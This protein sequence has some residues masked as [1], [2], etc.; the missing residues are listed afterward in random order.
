MAYCLMFILLLQ[1]KKI[2]IFATLPETNISPE[3]RPSQKEINIPTIHFQVLLLLVSGRVP[4]VFL[5]LPWWVTTSI[6]RVFCP[7]TLGIQLGT[8]TTRALR[9]C[10][11]LQ[12]FWARFLMAVLVNGQPRF[13]LG[14][15]AGSLSKGITI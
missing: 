5:G 1:L 6:L 3:N 2:G 4:Q 12:G 13:F 8:F 9:G 11:R 15:E 7:Q 10:R 14:E